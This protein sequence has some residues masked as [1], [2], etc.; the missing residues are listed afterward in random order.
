MG[1]DAVIVYEGGVIAFG[2]AG[3]ENEHTD[4]DEH[5]CIAEQRPVAALNVVVAYGENH[6][7]NFEAPKMQIFAFSTEKSLGKGS[8]RGIEALLF[9]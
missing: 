2:Q 1:N 7:R 6:D 3:L 4:V 5:Q 8:V 9:Q